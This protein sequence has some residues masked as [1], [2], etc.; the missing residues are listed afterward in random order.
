MRLTYT[1]EEDLRKQISTEDSPDA[2]CLRMLFEEL[3]VTR[4]AL[5]TREERAAL[6][7]LVRSQ[8]SP[9]AQRAKNWLDRLLAFNEG[10]N[11]TPLHQVMEDVLPSDEEHAAMTQLF[12]QTLEWT[13][14]ESARFRTWVSRFTAWRYPP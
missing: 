7:V 1:Q 10:T 3:D 9:R 8:H 11:M 6:N 5:P 13:D 14:K 12:V 4:A 2:D